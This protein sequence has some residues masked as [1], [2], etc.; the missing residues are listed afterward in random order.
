[1]IKKEFNALIHA[2]VQRV[3]GKKDKGPQTKRARNS[4]GSSP[5]SSESSDSEEEWEELMTIGT[6]SHRTGHSS[7]ITTT[8]VATVK[9]KN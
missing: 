3:L 2:Q 6:S 1:M 7:G 5:S 8:T 9:S 4:S